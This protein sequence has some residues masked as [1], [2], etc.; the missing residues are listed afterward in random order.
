MTKIPDLF[1][2]KERTYSIEL[3]PP[4]TDDGYAHLRETIQA[5]T[6]LKPDFFSCTYGAGGGNRSKTLDIVR[7]IQEEYGIPAMHHFTCVYHS[8]EEIKGILD[9][10]QAAGIDNILALR[11][12]P[13]PGQPHWTPGAEHFQY[14]CELCAFIRKHYGD[15]FGIGVAGFPE[16]HVLAPDKDRDAGYLKSKVDAG[17]DFVITQLFFD[18]RDYFGYMDRLTKLGVTKR[19]IPGIL[20]IT[21]YDSLIKFCAMCGASVP[22]KVHTIFAPIREDKQKMLEAGITFAIEQC[23]ELLDRGAPGLHFYALN[24]LEPVQTILNHVRR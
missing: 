5:L 23:E 1:T 9:D 20:P 17:A 24:K 10:I 15:S 19:V 7:H 3:F 14:S 11:G 12:D 22:E 18:N 13:P 8:R 6:A 4:K 16:G 21:N 2:V